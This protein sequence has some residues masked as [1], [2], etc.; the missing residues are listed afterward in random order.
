LAYAQ[1]NN[2]SVA[3]AL[4]KNFIEPLQNKKEYKQKIATSYGMLSQQSIS[5]I[6]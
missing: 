2:V 5:T 4:R 6:N 3:E 1:K